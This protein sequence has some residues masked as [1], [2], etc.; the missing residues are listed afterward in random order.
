MRRLMFAAIAALSPLAFGHFHLLEPQGWLV[1]SNLGD[2]QKL[3]P[4]G[5]TTANSGMPTNAVAK[6]QGGSKLHIKLQETVFH[7]GHYR[8]ALAV[9]SRAEL[10]P[11]PSTTTRDSDKGPWSMTAA[12]QNPP[13]MPVLADGLFAHTT[14]QSDAFETDIQL[15]NINCEKCTLQIIQFMAEH[16]LN[17]DGGFFYHHCADLQITADPSKALDAQWMR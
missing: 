8:V 2:P 17:K 6:V 12:I 5:G 7:P 3:G 11:D 14:R 16:G 4:C 1:E 13:K 9:K 15:P 10:P